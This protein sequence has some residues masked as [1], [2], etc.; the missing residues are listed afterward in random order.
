MKKTMVCLLWAALVLLMAACGFSAPA[1]APTLLTEPPASTAPAPTVPARDDPFRD[2]PDAQTFV[3]AMGMGWNLGNTL[4][5]VGCDWITDELDYET[6]W[7][8]PRTTKTLIAY[9]KSRG[10]DT[11]RVPVTWADHLSSDNTVSPVWMERV[12]Q[13]VEWCVEEDL[14]VIINMQHEDGWLTG[15]SSDYDGVMEKYRAIWTQIALRFRGY[16]EKLVFE[17]MNEIGFENLDTKD[18]CAL[19]NRINAEFT[20]LIRGTGGNNEKRYLLLAGY[21]ADMD[22]SIKGGI[23]L[24]DDNR[25]ILSIHY[26]APPAFAI[27]DASS[28]WGYQRTWGTE[29]DF[30]YL[31]E[32]FERLKS[33]YVDRGVPVIIGEF[34]AIH[35]DKDLDDVVLYTASIIEYAL[36]YR[37]CP[38]WWDNGSEIDRTA[39]TFR[40]DG[41]EDAIAAAKENGL[42]A[43][44]AGQE[45]H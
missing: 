43:R 22:K 39:L 35:T 34:G 33:R 9:V 41:M 2:Y 10:F 40:L 29:G 37:M 17:S 15:A 28:E 18:G 14:Y 6:A 30:A 45:A 12:A 11:V 8:N 1:E 7:E 42:A 32:Q 16:S 3:E 31:K 13:I 38:I 23:V 44:P 19:L 21:L 26:Y 4:D 36:K 5:P 20:A 24:P 25:T 27:A